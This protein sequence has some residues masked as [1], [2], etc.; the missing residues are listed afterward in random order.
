MKCKLVTPEE[1]KATLLEVG[2]R[3]LYEF[4]LSDLR[5][6]DLEGLDVGSVKQDLLDKDM[7]FIQVEENWEG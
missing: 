2:T 1:V 3:K 5:G 6:C 4:S 7:I